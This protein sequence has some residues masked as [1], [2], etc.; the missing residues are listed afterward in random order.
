MSGNRPKRRHHA[1]LRTLRIAAVGSLL[2]VV[3]LSAS[4]CPGELDDPEAFRTSCPDV[5]TKWFPNTCAF[6][7][8]H[9]A[10][11]QAAGLDLESPGLGSR[12]AGKTS[13]DNCS[14]RPV[15]NQKNPKGSLLYLKL[16]PN[17]GCGEQM[18]K[19]GTPFTQQE[20][21]C[22]AKWIGTLVGSGTGGSSTGGSSTGGSGTGNTGAGAS[23]T[24]GA[25]G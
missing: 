13:T 1:P 24:G 8:C 7:T 25:G 11:D 16:T 2:T 6:G 20:L 18:P 17:S 21:E 19:G 5:E 15:A 14:S 23:G 3:A 22:V 4:G 9:S 12:V 10:T